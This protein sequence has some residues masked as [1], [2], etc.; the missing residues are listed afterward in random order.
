MARPYDK[1]I[2]VYEMVNSV[3]IPYRKE[4][5]KIGVGRFC[6]FLETRTINMTRTFKYEYVVFIIIASSLARQII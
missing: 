1:L 3:I 6:Q 4:G 2:I 5:R